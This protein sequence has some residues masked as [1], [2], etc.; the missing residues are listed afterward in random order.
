MD[1]VRSSLNQ[2]TEWCKKERDF[3]KVQ[4]DKLEAGQLTV[5]EAQGEETKAD[6]TV[7]IVQLVIHQIAEL[8]GLLADEDE[9]DTEA[10]AKGNLPSAI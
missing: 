8:N 2:L 10:D 4:L 6:I 9:A 5:L 7:D 1:N 3:L